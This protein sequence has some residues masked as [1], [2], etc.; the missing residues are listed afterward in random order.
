M[1]KINI[2]IRFFVIV[3]MVKIFVFYHSKYHSKNTYNLSL[4]ILEF[5]SLEASLSDYTSDEH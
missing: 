1:V 3:I 2:Y 5:H 4:K